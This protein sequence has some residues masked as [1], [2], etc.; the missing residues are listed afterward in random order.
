MTGPGKG[1]R[2]PGRPEVQRAADWRCR[3]SEAECGRRG[4]RESEA[5]SIPSIE[6]D[7]GLDLNNPEIMT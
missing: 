2:R 6:P 5:D 7:T 4:E 1:G 3:G